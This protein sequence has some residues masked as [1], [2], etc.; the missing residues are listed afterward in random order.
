IA[1]VYAG[2]VSSSLACVAITL[3]PTV[4]FV[5]MAGA[6]MLGLLPFTSPPPTDA[7]Q[8]AIFNLLVLNIVGA[9]AAL[10]A[11]AYR[12]SRYRLAAAYG[13]LER[14]HDQSLRMHAQIERAGRLYA[15]SEVVAG[16]APQA[17]HEPQ[18]GV[19]APLHAAREP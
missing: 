15:V 2:S 11:D 3:L 4:A 9:L 18:R 5:T 17:R 19:G 12:R 7:W 10:L 16:R 6:Q 14:A 13:E 1:P 8:T